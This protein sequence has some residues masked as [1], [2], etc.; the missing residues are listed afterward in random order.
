MKK[1]LLLI[2]TLTA[3]GMATA[4]PIDFSK[5]SAQSNWVVH[6]DMEALRKSKV[7]AFIIS[8]AKENPESAKGIN[9]LKVVFG[10]DVDAIKHIA[11]FGR[12]EPNKAIFT[13][14]GGFDTER[15]QSMLELN[16]SYSA[17]KHGDTVIHL[18]DQNTAEQKAIAFTAKDE[19]VGSNTTGFTQHQ[20]DVINGKSPSLENTGIYQAITTALPHP[21]LV[22]AANVK[23]VAEFSKPVKGPE[24][25][26]IQ[27]TN[28]IGLAVSESNGM[29]MA[30]V[31]LEAYDEETA[32]HVENIARGFT[33]LLALGGDI[34]PELAELLSKTKTKVARKGRTV[35]IKV[36][37]DVEVV[38]E[39]IAREMAKQQDNSEAPK[40][41]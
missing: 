23:G 12:G 9:M 29:L 7:G 31:L 8:K 38:T 40:E 30:V 37:I 39:L 17:K 11:A 20:V 5:V 34:E 24:A 10:L 32:V 33:S 15:L 13:A 22:G 27:K 1:T 35:S 41:F 25:V 26:I 36:G 19:L 18:V 28:A 21:I 16:E 3:T 14:K 2:A 6:A 4:G